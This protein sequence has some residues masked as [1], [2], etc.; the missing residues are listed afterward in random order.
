MISR[1]AARTSS[2]VSSGSTRKF[3]VAVARFGTTFSLTPP[4]IIV[5]AVVVRSSRRLE[6][7]LGQASLQHAAGQPEI[8]HGKSAPPGQVRR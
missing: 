8:V 4:L 7:V 2:G 5:A 1:T 3:T 6:G